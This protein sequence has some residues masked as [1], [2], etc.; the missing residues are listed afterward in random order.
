MGTAVR[1]IEIVEPA[2]VGYEKTYSTEKRRIYCDVAPAQTVAALAQAA[3]DKTPTRSRSISRYCWLLYARA[4]AL[5][6]VGKL[7]EGEAA[8]TP[9]RRARPFN[10]RYV[11]ELAN[12]RRTT[13]RFDLA[14]KDMRRRLRSPT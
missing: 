10:S 6:D 9:S 13:H 8:F 1:A 11:F 2:I 3:A 7:P 5:V 12:T 4:F 14:R